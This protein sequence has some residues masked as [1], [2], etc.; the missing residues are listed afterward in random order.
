VVADPAS[1]VAFATGV[2]LASLGWQLTLAGAASLAGARLPS[3]LRAAT[4]VAGYLLVLGY[5]LRLALG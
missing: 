2:L 4:S 3:W 5:A 1:R